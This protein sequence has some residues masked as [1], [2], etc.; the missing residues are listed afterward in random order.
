M[1][2]VNG[3]VARASD[4]RS[5]G[6][7]FALALLPFVLFWKVALGRM[8]FGEGDLLAYN[9]PLVAEMLGNELAGSL[10]GI[11]TYSAARLLALMQGRVLP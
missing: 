11:R 10:S 2:T 3:G 6:G 9:Y 5:A 4:R 1:E 8:I 7:A